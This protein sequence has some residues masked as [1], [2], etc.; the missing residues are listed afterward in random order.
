[1]KQL[2]FEKNRKTPALS[3][4]YHNGNNCRYRSNEFKP[5]KS[6]YEYLKKE[7]NNYIPSTSNNKL[8]V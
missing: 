8:P 3:S 2:S 5:S 4:I 6:K 7:L 1:M